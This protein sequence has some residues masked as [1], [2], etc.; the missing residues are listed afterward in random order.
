MYCVSFHIDY[1]QGLAVKDG[2]ST[3]VFSTSI[4]KGINQWEFNKSYLGGTAI[5]R[6]FHGAKAKQIKH[7]VIPTLIEECPK[8]VVLQCGGNDLPT[9]KLNPTTVESIAKDIIDTGKLCENHGA[10]QIL[11]SGIIARN[12][13]EYMEKRRNDLNELLKDMCFDLG[14]I[15]IDNDNIQHEHLYT[16]GVHLNHDG[17]YI[18]SNNLLHSLNNVF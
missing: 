18:L 17:S 6:R 14:F 13:H 3:V 15:Y 10:E 9:R 16:D 1:L 7:Y 4:T 12:K 2:K 5:F 11:I 8:V